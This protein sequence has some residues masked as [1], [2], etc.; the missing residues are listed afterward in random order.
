MNK[1]GQDLGQLKKK[2]ATAQALIKLMEDLSNKA[3]PRMNKEEIE[4]YERFMDGLRKEES[5]LMDEIFKAR[6]TVQ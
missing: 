2:L 1:E 6:G 4:R 5:L 3:Q